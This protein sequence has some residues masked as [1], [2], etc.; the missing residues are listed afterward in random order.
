MTPS[1]FTAALALLVLLYTSFLGP[2]AFAAETDAPSADSTIYLA[3]GSYAAGQLVDLPDG[4][5]LVWQ[6]RAFTAPFTFPLDAV[7][8]VHFPVPA[9][10][11]QPL[12]DYCFE[13]T[14]GDILFGGLTS[15]DGDAAVLDVAGLGR[16]HVA[17]GI[18][19][20]MFRWDGADL[21]YFGPSG[22]RGWQSIGKASWREEA[23]HLVADEKSASI[24]RDFALPPRVCLEFELSWTKRPDFELALGVPTNSNSAPHPFR[25]EVWENQLVALRGTEREADVAALEDIKSGPGRI[26]FLAFLDQE[27]ERLLVVSSSGRP[28]ADLTVKSAKPQVLGG[29]QLTN[30]KGDVRLE[31]LR[32]SRWSGDAPRIADTDK[33]R[34]HATN[35][36][37]AYGELKSYDSASQEFVITTESGDHRLAQKRLHDV[38]FSAADDGA[39][40]DDASPSLRAVHLAGLR[41]SGDLVKIEKQAV[42]MKRHGIQEALISPLN[43]LHALTVLKRGDKL[44]E[45]TGRGG[46][47]ELEGA[48]LR[49]CLVDGREGE[50]SCLVW[51]PTH[52][53]TASPLVR[54][55]AARVVYRDPPTITAQPPRA[56]ANM[57]RVQPRLFNGR[58]VQNTPTV[59]R[60][61]PSAQSV[62]HL[63]SGDTFPCTVA[64]IDEKGIT[65]KS[66]VTDATF[67]P[68][69]QIKVL[70]LMPEASAVAIATSKKERLLTLPRMQRDNPPTHLIRAY[71]GD[72]LRGRL[73][74]M[75]DKQLQVE[76]RLETT[77]VLREN[78]ARII[79]L[80]PEIDAEAKP[81]ADI[82][83][84]TRV[85]S[86]PADGNRL[87][88]F[89]EQ[90][91]GSTLSGKSDLLGQCRVDVREVDQLLIGAAIEQS[92]STL[93]FHQWKLKPALEPLAAEEGDGGDTDGLSSVLVGKPAP[94]F[95]LD[96]L[97]GG[98][99]NLSAQKGQII[100]LDF[101]ASWCAPCLQVMPQVDKV[102]QEFAG[103]NVKLVSINMQEEPDRIRTVLERLNLKTAVALD[104]EGLIAEKY[105][106]ITIPQTVIIDRDGAV[107]RLFVT[108]SSRFDEQ[109]RAALQSV[110]A[111]PM[112]T[113]AAE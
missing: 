78:I 103:E 1:R 34:I 54:G 87:T 40:D 24:R 32:I 96:L 107:A 18:L 73:M 8:V 86:L 55:V 33:A 4:N 92:A 19:R 57:I 5:N 112:K 80:H 49:G 10:L 90:M 110:I 29:L 13:L 113:D 94:D 44:P 53:S 69:A 63:R 68:H 70:E 22:L 101:W 79:W 64:A 85:Q 62:L 72:Y 47:L 97:D 9:K 38:V 6:S 7:N 25:F 82:S 83:A 77:T 41:V 50:A 61:R 102:A 67:V 52:S 11:P 16:L 23:G 108:A 111:G 12:G 104:R 26:H 27:K 42:W 28:L 65:I 43:S 3:N 93:A 31:R 89:A 74:A 48:A 76:I 84:V 14:G 59:P 109:L 35:G 91:D 95:Q 21:L 71:N 2:R 106:A 98:R 30:R 99:F 88:F 15:L 56:R 100:V 58:V 39:A 37:I 46:R 20:R 51:Q 75:D 66:G 81:L 60:R 17:R 36:T 105:G 45:L